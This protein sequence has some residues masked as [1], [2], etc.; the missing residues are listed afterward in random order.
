M[1]RRKGEREME[2]RR[3]GER[4]EGEGRRDEGRRK[5]RKKGR[6][7]EDQGWQLGIPAV[8]AES[9]RSLGLMTTV[10]A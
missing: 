6:R 10:F 4:M 9:G 7:K 1:G 3:K 5:E 8:E 2:G